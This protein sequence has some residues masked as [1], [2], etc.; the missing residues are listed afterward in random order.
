M[1]LVTLPARRQSRRNCIPQD[2]KRVAVAN[3]RFTFYVPQAITWS[4]GFSER[5]Y[6]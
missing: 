5:D 1:F 3:S 2:V 6:I 4:M